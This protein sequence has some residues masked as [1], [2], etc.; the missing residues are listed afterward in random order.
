MDIKITW[1]A[2]SARGS[3]GEILLGMVKLVVVG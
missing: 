2:S 3:P 1:A